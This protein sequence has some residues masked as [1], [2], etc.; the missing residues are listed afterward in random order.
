[1]FLQHGFYVKLLL[2]R[3]LVQIRKGFSELSGAKL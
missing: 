3:Y 1:M 2:K